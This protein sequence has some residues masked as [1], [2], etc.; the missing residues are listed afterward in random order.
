MICSIKVLS[1]FVG[2]VRMT[3]PAS[4][5]P[6]A[7]TGTRARRALIFNANARNIRGNNRGAATLRAGSV[8][9]PGGSANDIIPGARLSGFATNA[10][11]HSSTAGDRYTGNPA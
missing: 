7:A 2:D 3:P 6:G 9:W 1:L 11:P 4:R 5:E 10:D 8:G